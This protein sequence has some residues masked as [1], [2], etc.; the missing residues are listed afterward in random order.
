MTGSSA[1]RPTRMPSTGQTRHFLCRQHG[2][3][4]QGSAATQHT[5]TS[6]ASGLQV[7]GPLCLRFQALP[8][9]FSFQET[10]FSLGFASDASP[11]LEF[12]N[13]PSKSFEVQ[14]KH[15]LAQDELPQILNLEN[16]SDPSLYSASLACINS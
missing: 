13:K 14:N 6:R 1:L 9:H 16:P 11:G 4:W 3:G 8:Q 2:Q 10:G 15:K 12:P 5:T 7:A